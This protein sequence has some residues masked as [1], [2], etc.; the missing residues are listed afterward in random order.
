M[1]GAEHSRGAAVLHADIIRRGLATLLAVALLGL[2]VTSLT[3]AAVLLRNDARRT[4]QLQS[5]A[6][7]R[8]LLLAGA[9]VPLLILKAGATPRRAASGDQSSR[10]IPR[11]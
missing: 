4:R 1:R 6:Q 2:V 5:D 3:A 8:Q 7:L 9:S 11:F 10:E